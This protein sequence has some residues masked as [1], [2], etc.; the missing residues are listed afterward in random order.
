MLFRSETERGSD[1]VAEDTIGSI[2]FE[3]IDWQHRRAAHLIM[4]EIRAKTADIPGVLIEVTAPNAGPPTGKAIQVQLAAIDP[5]QL[6]PAARKV[7]AILQNYPDIRDID[8]G[9]SLPGIDWKID[10]DKA[11]AAKFGASATSVG[12]ALQLVTNGLKVS[13]YRPND[14]DKS[15]DLIVRF[16][17]DKRT[18]DNIEELLLNTFGFSSDRQFRDANTK[19]QRRPD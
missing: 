4:D 8:N 14:T 17:E 12:T 19:C 1:E 15:V 11:E 2:Q 18:L 10:V 6:K 7:E 9:L 3:F 5:A 13:E 16:P